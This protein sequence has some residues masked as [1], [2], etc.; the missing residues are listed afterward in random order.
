MQRHRGRSVHGQCGGRDSVDWVRETMMP[1]S[2]GGLVVCNDNM[3]FTM[4]ER[5]D[6]EGY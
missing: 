3:V 1:H 2:S 4:S 5:D 6:S